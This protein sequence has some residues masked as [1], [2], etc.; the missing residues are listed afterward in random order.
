MNGFIP[1]GGGST[2]FKGFFATE[3]ALNIA[4]PTGTSGD[5]AIV[6]STDTFW[7]VGRLED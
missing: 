7:V 4:Y 2:Y 3:S 6:G 5:Y 1:I